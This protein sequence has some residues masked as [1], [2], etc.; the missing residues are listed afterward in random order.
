MKHILICCLRRAAD[1]LILIHLNV[2]FFSFRYINGNFVN[3]IPVEVTGRHLQ[4]VLQMKLIRRSQPVELNVLHLITQIQQI[5]LQHMIPRIAGLT[6]YCVEN[7]QHQ[8][9]GIDTSQVIIFHCHHCI[10][11]FLSASRLQGEEGCEYTS[12]KISRRFSL[13][14]VRTN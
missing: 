5:K 2:W 9:G 3:P 8:V 4:V 6:G 10:L 13:R 11:L 14:S 12:M 7:M 1:F